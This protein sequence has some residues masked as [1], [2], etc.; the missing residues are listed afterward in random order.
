MEMLLTGDLIS[1]DKALKIGLINNIKENENLKTY[2]ETS[3]L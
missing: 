2:V 1:S 3:S